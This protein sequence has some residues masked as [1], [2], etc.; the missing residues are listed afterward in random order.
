MIHTN[1]HYSVATVETPE[2]LH[3]WLADHTMTLC[4]GFRLG[5]TLWLNDSFSENG[6]QEYAV[7]RNGRQI[8]S[9]TVSWCTPDKLLD[10]IVRLSEEQD[11]EDFGPVSLHLETPEEHRRCPLCA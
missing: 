10:T 1:R 2:E 9:I 11:S 6:A 3:R 7:I 8:E 5:E 4:T